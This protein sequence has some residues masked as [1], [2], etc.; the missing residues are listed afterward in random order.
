MA[1]RGLHIISA[2]L[3]H[4]TAPVAVRERV[5]FAQPRLG[6]ALHTLAG[7]PAV[8]EAA[9]LSTCNRAELYCAS[10]E[11]EVAR[12]QVLEFVADYH[13]LD[14][15]DIHPH[16]YHL[17]DAEAARHLFRVAGGLDS[18]VLGENQILAQVK[19]ALQLA[20]EAG[21]LC[22]TLN[23]LFQRSLHIGKA[24]RSDT[25][26]ARGAV[27]ISAA[28]V[29]L[30]RNVFGDLSRCRALVIGAGE[31]SAQTLKLLCDYGV[32]SVVVANRTYQRAV[33]L[34]ELHGGAA[35]TFDE[36]PQHLAQTDIIVS[37][38]SAPHPILTVEKIKAQLGARRGRPLFIIDIAVPRD[39]E[40]AVAELPNV[41]LFD[42]DDLEQ[43]TSKYRQERAREVVKVEALV[44]RETDRFMHW[45]SARGVTPLISQL[46]S[47]TET[48]R[49]SEL[50]RWL[51]KAPELTAEQEEVVRQ[52]MRSFSNKLLHAPLTQMRQLAADQPEGEQVEWLRRLFDLDGEDG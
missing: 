31:M 39:V 34:A 44:E 32:Q 40:A 41:Y 23:E 28:A 26:I 36:F 29:D 13:R 27:S 20:R 30:A 17:Q 4:H 49:E 2:G 16:M 50:D 35:V 25:A 52:M 15:A 19:N 18:M 48:L 45:L 38:S 9:I 24:A 8:A 1:D 51:R 46:R 47:K 12:R 22:G 11:P 7:Q 21:T 42:I 6:D 43:V 37:S 33:E 14:P 3:N 10:F 5:A